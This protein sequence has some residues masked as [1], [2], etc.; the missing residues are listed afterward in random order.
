MAVDGALHEGTG[1]IDKFMGALRALD[2]GQR[3]EPPQRGILSVV[4]F[5]AVRIDRVEDRPARRCALWCGLRPLDRLGQRQAI[6]GEEEG[7]EE[8]ETDYSRTGKRQAGW[9]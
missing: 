5:V 2:F 7:E 3:L 4:G 9:Q 6:G 1:G 8:G